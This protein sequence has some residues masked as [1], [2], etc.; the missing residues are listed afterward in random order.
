PDGVARSLV[1]LGRQL[2]M[3]PFMVLLGAFK[4]LLC[5]YSGHPDVVVLSPFANR[6]GQG[7]EDLIGCIT[8]TVALRTD[9]Y[10]D[11]TLSHVLA[12]VR[13]VCLDAYRFQDVPFDAVVQAMKP[14]W[15]LYADPPVRFTLRNAT[16]FLERA[17]A[18]GL[19]IERFDAET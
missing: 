8:N 16:P 17:A 1:D 9:L 11:P 13:D 19:T 10:G 18:S 3:T 7:T 6:L 14:D 4:V 2:S 15:D 5:R 12:R